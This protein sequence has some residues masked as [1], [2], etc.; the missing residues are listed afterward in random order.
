MRR[1][2]DLVASAASAALI[3]VVALPLWVQPVSAQQGVTSADP[4][5]VSIGLK[6]IFNYRTDNKGLKDR[7]NANTVTVVLGPLNGTY[8]NFGADMATALDDGDNLRIMPVVGKGSVK[9]IADILFV[10]GVD[11][12]MVRAD[13]LD[14]LDRKGYVQNIRKQITYI[15]KLYNEEIHVVAGKSVRRLQDL[16]GKRVAID[17]PDGGTFITA[18]TIFELLGIR[19]Q[20]SH[21]EQRLAQE[22]LKR[23]E[24]D[25]FVAVQ[26]TP[27]RSVAQMT[28]DFHLVPIEYSA[29]LQ[30]G[31]FPS[32]LDAKDY[33]TLLEPGQRIDT[34]SVAAI[35]AGYNWPEKTERYRKMENFTQIFFNKFKTLQQPPFHPKW[36]EVALGAPLKGWERFKPAQEWLDQHASTASPEIRSKFDQFLAARGSAR[37][38]ANSPEQNEAL[39]QQFLRWQASQNAPP[40]RPR[41]IAPVAQ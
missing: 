40:P 17:L 8:L 28:G 11:L 25:A 12:G 3:A 22:K 29:P 18:H 9:S 27:S 1:A 26:G 16:E 15:T 7:L 19:A 33:P 23:G 38:G 32:T 41:S 6:A 34:V 5:S 10:R 4:E 14:Y 31:Y 13:T 35:L 30:A 20:F 37:S 21:M 36:K 39:F 2:F 24:I